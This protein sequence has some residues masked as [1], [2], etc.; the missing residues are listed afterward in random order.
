MRDANDE[1]FVV[2]LKN[3]M[4]LLQIADAHVVL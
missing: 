2:V 1:K 3:W 4:I